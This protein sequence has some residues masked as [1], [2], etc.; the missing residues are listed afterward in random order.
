MRIRRKPYTNIG[1][2]RVPCCRCGA[3][4][5][6]QWQ[7]CADNNQWRGL[8]IPCDVALNKLVLR[9]MNFRDWRE[10]LAVYRRKWGI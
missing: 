4:S 8:C 5:F 7:I 3:P 9:F 2:A 10:K 6:H 1:I